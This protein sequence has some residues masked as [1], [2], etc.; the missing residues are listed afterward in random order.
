MKNLWEIGELIEVVNDKPQLEEY[1]EIKTIHYTTHNLEHHATNQ[2]QAKL[3]V[4]HNSAKAKASKNI[5]INV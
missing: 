5:V 3:K 1:H 2:N 4:P